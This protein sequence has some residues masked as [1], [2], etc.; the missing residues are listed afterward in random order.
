MGLLI[1]ASSP[2]RADFLNT[3]Q[4]YKF[5]PVV[6]VAINL[7]TYLSAQSLNDKVITIKSLDLEQYNEPSFDSFKIQENEILEKGFFGNYFR[8][9][10]NVIIKKGHLKQL[11]GLKILVQSELPIGSGLASSAALEVAFTAL[12]N[13]VCNLGFTKQDIAEIAFIAETEEVG[14]PCGRLDQ[15]G[16]T[17]GGIMNL[18][19][20]PPYNVE[21]LP[22]TDLTFAIIDSGI[23]HSTGNIH[24]IRQAELN[25][26]LK[27]LM[28]NPRLSRP[29]RAKLGYRF[30]QPKWKT[31]R[32]EEL[33]DFL[34]EVDEKA[35]MRLLFTIKMQKLT[36]FA[37]K[38]LRCERISSED[39]RFTLEKEKWEHI[40]QYPRSEREYWI[41]GE[42]MN[43]QQSLLRDL[44]DVSLPEIEDICTTALEIGAYGVKISGAGKGGSVIAL[45]KDAKLGQ[46][47]ITACLSTGA[48]KGWVSTIGDGV[49][50]QSLKEASYHRKKTI[51]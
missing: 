35:M 25:S 6:P 51:V 28:E 2:G 34:S 17:F 5:L 40:T 37:L 18:E 11:Q 41:L 9:I 30:D 50:V 22:F 47:V 33:N 12:L 20:Q 26:G 8:G 19:C 23:R 24:P 49:N 13:S 38:I 36:E 7:R 44:Y 21:S 15:Y 46:K 45:V 10:V 32:E 29:L 39:L 3:H 48:K 14:V 43:K 1:Q 16:V 27:M 4:D 42:V 31:I